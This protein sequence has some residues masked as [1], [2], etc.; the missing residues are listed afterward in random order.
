MGCADA[1][2]EPGHLNDADSMTED[3]DSLMLAS[4]VL[5]ASS[6]DRSVVSYT[7]G[8]SGIPPTRTHTLFSSVCTHVETEFL[9]HKQQ[10]IKKNEPILPS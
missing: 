1:A 4:D 2:V 7:H 6:D 5:A 3:G 8:K 10:K 9:R